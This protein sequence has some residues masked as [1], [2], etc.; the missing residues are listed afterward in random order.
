MCYSGGEQGG[1]QINL[2]GI[3]VGLGLVVKTSVV[4]GQIHTD[5]QLVLYNKRQNPRQL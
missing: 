1:S 4:F 2:V 3:G 5:L